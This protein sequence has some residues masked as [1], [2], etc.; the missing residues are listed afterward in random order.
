MP[1]NKIEITDEAVPLEVE[2]E[3]RVF[4]DPL[5][6]KIVMMNAANLQKTNERISEWDK[7]KIEQL[8]R[9]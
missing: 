9:E 5:V 6:A 8:T 4:I 1:K 3:D 7:K 2:S